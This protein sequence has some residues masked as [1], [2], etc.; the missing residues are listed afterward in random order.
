MHR[1]N[2]HHMASLAVRIWVQ[3]IRDMANLPNTVAELRAEMYELWRTT[4]GTSPRLEQ[5]ERRLILM[6]NGGPIDSRLAETCSADV[7]GLVHRYLVELRELY[8]QSHRP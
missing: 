8:R 3:H 7:E 1:Q 4:D 5:I 6:T 2:E